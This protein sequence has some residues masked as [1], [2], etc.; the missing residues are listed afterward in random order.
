MDS[1]IGAV[2]A[3]VFHKSLIHTEQK[4]LRYPR[5]APYL[6]TAWKATKEENNPASYP[7]RL[8]VLSSW[9]PVRMGH[10]RIH[11]LR[12]ALRVLHLIMQHQSW[13]M[14]HAEAKLFD[15]FPSPLQ[16]RSLPSGFFTRLNQTLKSLKA[17]QLVPAAEDCALQV[18]CEWSSRTQNYSLKWPTTTLVSAKLASTVPSIVVNSTAGLVQCK[19]G[20]I[21]F[22]FER[23]VFKKH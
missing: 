5:K 17:A 21:Y 11:L 16:N 2:A 6:I 3:E 12:W 8:P 10:P 13:R 18:W 7:E 19:W 4:N 20:L 22:L 23:P 9:L 14:S 1:S 15:Y